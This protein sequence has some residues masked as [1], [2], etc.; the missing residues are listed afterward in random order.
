MAKKKETAEDLF[1]LTYDED[2]NIRL[3]AA[4]QLA[5]FKDSPIATFAMYELTYDK[6]DSVKEFAKNVILTW[7]NEQI[8]EGT[9][10]PL[11]E[12]LAEKIVKNVKETE[13]GEKVNV[14]KTVES[15]K[16]DILSAINGHLDINDKKRKELADSLAGIFEKMI[17][18]RVKEG[19]ERKG[20]A[21]R[22]EKRDK[23][24]KAEEEGAGTRPED[25][26]GREKGEK[27]EDE[28]ELPD[29]YRTYLEVLSEIERMLPAEIVRGKRPE[30]ASRK[31]AR[32]AMSHGQAKLIEEI[33]TGEEDE[34]EEEGEEEKTLKP[35]RP[36]M[37]GETPEDSIE[38]WVYEKAYE[39]L[40]IPNTTPGDIT[41]GLNQLE[42]TMVL[43]TRTGINMA[44]MSA[45]H[46]TVHSIS[47]LRPGMA[48]IYTD[49][50]KVTLVEDKKIKKVKKPV[51][52]LRIIVADEEGKNFTVYLWGDRGRGIYENDYIKFENAVVETYPATGE[53]VLT[54]DKK[55]KVYI[56]R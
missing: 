35:V 18:E 1:K 54:V 33:K 10:M 5:E 26:E 44:K 46:R 32:E 19:E 36:S 56:V 22:E 49:P 34:E 9:L 41:R 39:L 20:R 2:A 17:K 38:N 21:D 50:L 14:D 7:K 51:S 29:D 11:D 25:K 30:L 13:M 16:N 40:T 53:T 15:M 55:G 28:G 48:G 23:G 24:G 27:E 45:K 37:R 6:A 47:E 3:K 12:I 52:C 8:Q 31:E 42:K 43:K 4:R